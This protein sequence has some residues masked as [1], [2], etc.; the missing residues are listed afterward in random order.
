MI[1]VDGQK[2][3]I[4]TIVKA[5]S[6]GSKIQIILDWY[7][8]K[9]KCDLQ[10]SLGLLGYKLTSSIRSQVKQER[11]Y[12]AVD[13][14][15]DFLRKID[16]KFIKNQETI[17]KPIIND[18][19]NKLYIMGLTAIKRLSL[20]LNHNIFDSVNDLLVVFQTETKVA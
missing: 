2:T 20:R 18:Q 7:H 10:F 13:Y 9:K 14:A 6:W 11:R 1:E 16:V 3:L 5:F 8:L 17:N 15:H 4:D 12:G 19:R